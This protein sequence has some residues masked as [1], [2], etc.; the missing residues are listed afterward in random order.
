METLKNFS[1]SGSFAKF[2]AF[3]GLSRQGAS[4]KRPARFVAFVLAAALFAN[5][6]GRDVIGQERPHA[7]GEGPGVGAQA[8]LI[9]IALVGTVTG[10]GAG[11][12][13]AVQQAHTVKGCT[14]DNPNGLLL[15]MQDGK[16]YVLLGNTTSIKA[17]ERIKVTGSRKKKI[18]GI[19]DQPSFVVEKLDKVYGTC[20][21][22]PVT[23]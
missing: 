18:K 4:R 14:I 16:T 6:L 7:A 12:Y 3:A 1:K 22:A 9:T 2:L 10:I 21:V 8:S 17:N 19:T 11:V 23:P 20:S 5:S 15:Q 13:F